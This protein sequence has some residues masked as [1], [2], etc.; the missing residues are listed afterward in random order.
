MSE[1]TLLQLAET[2]T[3]RRQVTAD[4]SYTRQLMD[5]GIGKCTKK[6]GEEAVEVVIAALNESDEALK[7]EVA[8]LF[9]HLL[10]VLEVR[11]V[12]LNDIFETLEARMEQSGL[13]EKASRSK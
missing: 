4:T 5:A 6:F 12:K 1:N 13:T 9:Y 11:G 2:I 7:L 3:A 10:V 8:D